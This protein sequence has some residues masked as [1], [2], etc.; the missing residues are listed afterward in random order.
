M[1]VIVTCGPAIEPI[2]RVRCITNF[3]TG[4]L[5]IMLSNA[6]AEHGF[7]V[8]CLK[9]SR[10]TSPL[11]LDHVETRIFDTNDDLQTTLEKLASAEILA[12]FHTAALCDFRVKALTGAHSG[13][14]NVQKISSRETLQ[15]TL[16]PAPKL[17]SSLRA[18]F[19][20]A[21]IVGWKY[22]LDGSKDDALARG[23][24]QIAANS[25]DACVVNG[26]AYGDGFAFCEK[27]KEPQNLADKAKLC[28]FLTGWLKSFAV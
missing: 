20:S 25:S 27:E 28:A 11:P 5:G 19:P 24:Q 10:A 7:E 23:R 18:L 6:L 13:T 3:S 4:E 14:A 22:E 26:S 9:G 16:E 1:K 17:I 8:I 15:L 21:K 2:D 12:V